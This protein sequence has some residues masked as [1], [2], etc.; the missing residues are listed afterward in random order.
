M[1]VLHAAGQGPTAIAKQ[2]NAEGWHPAKRRETFNAAM[3][4]DL[5]VRLG[6]R[7]PPPA[8]AVP[9]RSPDEWTLAELA[10]HLD[11]P[12]PTLFAW[13]RR[14]RLRGRQHPLPPVRS[15]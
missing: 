14:G 3:L 5:Q 2:L 4:G 13:L 15:G 6:L 11:M 12:Q 9:H 10:H 8:A 7:S 1:T